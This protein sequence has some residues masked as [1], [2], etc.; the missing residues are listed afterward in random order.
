M[1]AI[2]LIILFAGCIFM[3]LSGTFQLLGLAFG[4]EGLSGVIIFWFTVGIFY[5]ISSSI[6]LF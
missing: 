5:V 2:L 6:G 3:M 4:S 1:G